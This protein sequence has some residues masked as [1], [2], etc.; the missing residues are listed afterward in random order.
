MATLATLAALALLTMAFEAP[1]LAQR[2]AGRAP[3]KP[4]AHPPA[5]TA[6]PDEG[7][8]PA[9]TELTPVPEE[10]MRAA[11]GGITSEQVGRRAAATSYSAKASEETMRAAA[12]RVDVAWSSFL[13]RLTGT[14]R[15]TRA[16]P[17]TQTATTAN[18]DVLTV[19]PILDNY[20]L[21]ASLTVP[22]SDYFLRINQAYSAATRT[23]EAAEL[24][25]VAARALSASNG[26]TTFY[27]WLRARGAVVVAVQALNEQ[28]IHLK[29]A[30]DQFE[31]GGASR[32][33]V[34]RAETAVASA[35]LQVLR[36]TDLSDVSEKQVRVAVHAPAGER[37][38]PGESLETPPPPFQ[39]N[40]AQ[41][42]GEALASRFEVRSID[43]NAEAAR[44]QASAQAAARYPA[45]S[46]FGDAYFQNPNP[47]SVQPQAQWYP[48][49]DLGVQAIWSPNDILVGNGQSGDYAHRAAALEA[50]KQVTRDGIEIEVMQ[51][52]QEA[53]LSDVAIASTKRELASAT[54]AYRVARELFAEGRGTST[55]LT[56]AEGELTR[57]R[58]DALNAAADA[59]VARVRL[60]HA[61]G[62]DTRLAGR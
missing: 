52:F 47:R 43:A 44:K 38:A 16:S 55:T 13:P 22:I 5:V 42:T 2:A 10:L 39:G 30:R 33:D 53:R 49:Y 9:S 61:L 51:A 37:L 20:L 3:E 15:Y 60:E 57:A 31:G 7:V 28:R 1:A 25:A 41:L 62:R 14:A 27:A 58:L 23:R 45:V 11:P 32:A 59:R 21:Q 34:L 6:P 17:F 4:A 12:S 8:T 26:R 29:V 36:A 50:Q 24:D 54:E 18:G 46:A 35:E 48:A 19:T 56:D 40:L